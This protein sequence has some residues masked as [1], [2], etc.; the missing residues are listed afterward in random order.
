MT[1]RP[2][3]CQFINK[4]PQSFFFYCSTAPVGLGFRIVEV[5]RSPTDTPLG[6][7]P[8]D[9]SSAHSRNLYLTHTILTRD[10]HPCQ[11]QHSKERFQQ[12]SDR[13]LTPYTAR[14]P[15]SAPSTSA[16]HNFGKSN[17]IWICVSRFFVC[18]R[19]RFFCMWLMRN[20]FQMLVHSIIW[21]RSLFMAVIHKVTVYLMGTTGPIEKLCTG[22]QTSSLRHYLSCI[23]AAKWSTQKH[24]KWICT[25]HGAG[26]CNGKVVDV[27]WDVSGSK[28]SWDSCFPDRSYLWF[29]MV[30]PDKCRY[31]SSLISRPLPPKSSSAR[32]SALSYLRWARL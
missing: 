23:Q 19:Q 25:H 15:G 1:S 11:R 26:T 29:S 14:T 9:E 17:I 30:P 8:L 27:Y 18:R 28:V 32:C 7:T 4:C 22:I 2:Y 10:R 21:K 24:Q 5:P 3:S 6:R 31:S 13:R 20:Q 12:A 16:W